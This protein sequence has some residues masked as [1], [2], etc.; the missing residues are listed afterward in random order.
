[1]KLILLFLI[2]FSALGQTK[3]PGTMLGS[4]TVTSHG[5]TGKVDVQSVYFGGNA[6]ASSDCTTGNCMVV[7]PVGSKITTVSHNGTGTYRLNGI[8]GTKYNCTGQG[9]SVGSNMHGT[10]FHNRAAST[11]SYA[12]VQ[13]AAGSLS[14]NAGYA[15]ITCTGIP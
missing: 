7:N 10:A 2:S 5:A 12:T 9:Y 1:M 14:Y 15:S 13:I 6:T 11:S 4:G 8:D 3:I